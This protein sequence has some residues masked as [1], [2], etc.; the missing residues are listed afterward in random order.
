MGGPAEGMKRPD[1]WY[2]KGIGG[3]LGMF[4]RPDVKE[5][6]APPPPPDAS[7]ALFREISRSRTE[8]EL[9]KSRGRTAAMTFGPPRAAPYGGPRR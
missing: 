2:A 8:Q 1:K 3:R 6:A 5:P 7:E 4:D 9:R